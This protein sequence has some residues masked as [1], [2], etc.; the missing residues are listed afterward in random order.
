MF[1]YEFKIRK[2]G[3][4]SKLKAF[5]TIVVD[6]IME[7]HGFKI[8]EGSNGLFVTPPSHKG[9]AMID[10][11]ETEKYYDDITFSGEEG[12]D[13]FREIKQQ[14]LSEYSSGSSNPSRGDAA[15]AHVAKSTKAKEPDI[16]VEVVQ[17]KENTPVKQKETAPERTRK[18]LWGF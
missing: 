8:I 7:L 2:L 1:S 9:V 4:S 12:A 15:K 6:G 13:I 16:E 14:I 5:V 10:G 18:P 11:V 17:P 3:K